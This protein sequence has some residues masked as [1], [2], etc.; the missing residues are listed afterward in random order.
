MALEVEGFVDGGVGGEKSLRRAWTLETDPTSF[1]A[2]DLLMRILRAIVR[3][4]TGD[5]SIAQT[6]VY[7]G[8]AIRAQF[9]GRDRSRNDALPLEKSAQQFHRR[10]FVPPWL[11]QYFLHLTFSIDSAPQVQ[12]WSPLFGQFGGLIKLFPVVVHAASLLLAVAGASPG[13][14]VGSIL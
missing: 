1:S 7:Q 12:R 4:T 11:Y 9:V 5:M 2:S 3:P 13:N 6:K 14:G 8:G 10:S